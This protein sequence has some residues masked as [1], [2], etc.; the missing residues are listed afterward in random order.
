MPLRTLLFCGLLLLS[1]PGQSK[2]W[3]EL[4]SVGER[5]QA[6]QLLSE[7]VAQEPE[8]THENRV[9]L[10]HWQL[11]AAQFE[12]ALHT[13]KDLPAEQRGLRGRALYFLGRYE[14]CL[15]FL[16]Q[17]DPSELRMRVEAH[18]YLGQLEQALG[19]LPQLRKVF[20]SASVDVLLLEARDHQGRKQYEEAAQKFAAVRRQK[21]LEAE[22]LF[23][24]GQC[25]IRLKRTQ[26]ARTLLESHRR[27]IPLLDA[28]DFAQRG[29]DIA[30]S[31]APNQATV[32]EAWQALSEFDPQAAEHALV[33]YER[34]TLLAKD[35]ERTPI[36][37]RLAR[38]H[39]ETMKSSEAA[40]S[41]LA[42]AIQLS[43]DPRLRVRRAD[44]LV[45]LG[46]PQEALAELRDVLVLRPGDPAI[47]KRI[48]GIQGQ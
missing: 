12:G 10:V 22:A 13:A 19:L 46:R 37:L 21:P 18:K 41:T 26:E 15:E 20:G 29:V 48:A 45:E 6:I 39:W 14:E 8:S 16:G 44:Y 1:S 38:F 47:L 9:L 27:L 7:Q 3:V 11:A 17:E 40:L 33:A 4:W 2:P 23:G 35:G 43:V 36:A 32:A 42:K 25:Y 5:A 34:A 24:L 30:P 31:S 28:L